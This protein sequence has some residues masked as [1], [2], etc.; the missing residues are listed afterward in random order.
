MILLAGPCVIEN[1][2][3]TFKVADY[4]VNL[5][6]ELG[7]IELI[8][9]SSY[10][11]ANRTKLNSFTGLNKAEA[12]QILADIKKT[13]NVPIVTD[14]HESWECEEVAKYVDV[15]QIPAFLCRQTDLL[16]AAG[17]TG[18]TVNIKKG[19]FLAPEGMSFAVEKVRS[20][21]NNN[22]MLTERGTTFGYSSLVVDM[23]SFPIMKKNNVPVIMDATHSVQIPN[24]TAGVT[25]GN[26]EM[27]ETLAL[28][29][30]SAGADGLFIETHPNPSQALSDAGSQL[31]LDKIKEIIQKVLKLK[32][33]VDKL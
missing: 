18:K 17:K 2:E 32:Q 12:L 9:K 26:P 22:I 33:T 30:I 4:L 6:K 24:Q 31:Q 14:V 29:A 21:G 13:Y 10:K 20:T 3:T 1:R 5:A 16:I 27:I 19:Q 11:K 8:F 7:D 25:G 23:T 28:A 15:I